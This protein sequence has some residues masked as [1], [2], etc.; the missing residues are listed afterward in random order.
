MR[1]FHLPI[2]DVS[3]PDERFETQWDAASEELCSLLRGRLDVLVHCRGGLGR[4]GTIAARLLV[5][6]GMEPKKAIVNVRAARPGAI[7]TTEQQGMRPRLRARR[8]WKP[9]V[10][11]GNSWPDCSD[12][13]YSHVS[14][15]LS[16]VI[17]GEFSKRMQMVTKPPGKAAN[18]QK[19]NRAAIILCK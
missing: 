5:E 12:K 9:A 6:L 17:K 11:G 8:R 15:Q 18:R 7:E 10:W 19:K 3:I 4:A 14:V 1:W 16:S 13:K 2:A